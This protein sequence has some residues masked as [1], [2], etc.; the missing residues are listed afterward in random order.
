MTGSAVGV[1]CFFFFI[2]FVG[3]GISSSHYW[4]RSEES[5]AV[6]AAIMAMLSLLSM[7]LLVFIN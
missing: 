2:S 5:S 4:D 1:F 3:F 7:W 6:T